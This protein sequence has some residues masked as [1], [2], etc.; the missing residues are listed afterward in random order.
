MRPWHVGTPESTQ[1]HSASI[2][3]YCH[4]MPWTDQKMHQAGQWA[5]DGEPLHP[6]VATLFGHELTHHPLKNCILR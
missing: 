5:G 6:S 1:S 2:A 3:V 4:I